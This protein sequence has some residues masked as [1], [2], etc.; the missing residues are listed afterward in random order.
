MGVALSSGA[1]APCRDAGGDREAYNHGY[2]SRE[3]PQIAVIK[4]QFLL[5]AG[6]DHVIITNDE[7]LA[8]TVMAITVGKGAG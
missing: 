4:K 8:E 3:E 2:M 5:D 6:A 1:R 7:D